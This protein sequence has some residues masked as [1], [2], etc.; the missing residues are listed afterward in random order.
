M[1]LVS[2]YPR[3]SRWVRKCANCEAK[4]APSL[5]Q[6]KPRP[7]RNSSRRTVV[8]RRRTRP[9]DWSTR[10]T[11]MV[12]VRPLT[13]YQRRAMRAGQTTPYLD[14]LRSSIPSVRIAIIADTGHFPQID[15]SAQ[16]NSLL[17]SFLATLPA[18]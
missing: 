1:L 5:T 2:K 3:Q 4:A 17:D 10:S 9:V 7:L 18:V 11:V 14:M 13:R 6:M 16:T 12:R 15:E 8:R